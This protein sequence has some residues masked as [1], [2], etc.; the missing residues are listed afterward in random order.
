MV[1]LLKDSIRILNKY[2]QMH[3]LMI[4]NTSKLYVEK[5]ITA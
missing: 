3:T 4:L 2:F 1:K 5:G